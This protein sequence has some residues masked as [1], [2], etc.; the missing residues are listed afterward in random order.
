MSCSGLDS[1]LFR[2]ITKYESEEFTANAL[3]FVYM[4]AVSRKDPNSSE[5]YVILNNLQRLSVTGEASDRDIDALRSWFDQHVTAY[6]E[7]VPYLDAFAAYIYGEDDEI[8]DSLRESFLL[9]QTVTH[10]R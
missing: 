9:Q 4:E 2:F 10:R 1:G 6:D 8:R 3:A 7:S 5:H